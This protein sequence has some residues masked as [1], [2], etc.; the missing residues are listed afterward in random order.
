M[1][2]VEEEEEEEEEGEL[3]AEESGDEVGAVYV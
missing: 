2:E 1:A 3:V